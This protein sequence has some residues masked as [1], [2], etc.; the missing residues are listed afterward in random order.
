[1][2]TNKVNSVFRERDILMN[3]KTCQF[4]PK[5]HNAL[6]DDEYLYLVMEYISQGTLSTMILAN[7]SLGLSKEIV[8]FYAAQLV[9]T[10]E[11]L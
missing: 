11:Y 5:I 4:L 9:L 1:M 8:Q 6:V 2:K 3:N 7:S 10:L